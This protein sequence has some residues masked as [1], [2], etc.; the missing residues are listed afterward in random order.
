MSTNPAKQF[1]ANEVIAELGTQGPATPRRY[2]MASY[3]MGYIHSPTRGFSALL[4]TAVTAAMLAAIFVLH[5][6]QVFH[7][8]IAVYVLGSFAL[9]RIDHRRQTATEILRKDPSTLDEADT[10][11]RKYE[12][13]AMFS[14]FVVI[15][16]AVLA[17]HVLPTP[18]VAS[19][20]VLGTLLAIRGVLKYKRI[21][22]NAAAIMAEAPSQ[23]WFDE[24]DSTPSPAESWISA[25]LG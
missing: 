5:S 7:A 23:Y 21:D 22:A 17:I 10:I 11:K 18:L 24:Y 16:L 19:I 15:A 12:T 20:A 8:A 2:A 1:K 13:M 25:I 9:H 14:V 6:V 4:I 3:Y